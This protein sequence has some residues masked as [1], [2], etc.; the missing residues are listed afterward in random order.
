DVDRPNTD[1]GHVVL[2]GQPAAGLDELVVKLGPQERVVDR[3]GDVA[4]RQCLDSE[5]HVAA[6]AVGA[7]IRWLNATCW[8]GILAFGVRC[9]AWDAGKRPNRSE[10]APPDPSSGRVRSHGATRP[11]IRASDAANATAERRL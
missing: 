3:L 7:C 11:W 2:A 9:R 10:S 5:G 1:R 6:R 8:S 4:L